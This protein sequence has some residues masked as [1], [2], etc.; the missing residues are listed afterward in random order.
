MLDNEPTT[1]AADPAATAQPAARRTAK[2][3]ATKTTTTRK[4]TVKKT[5][6]AEEVPTQSDGETADP[7][8]VKTVSYTH[9]TLPTN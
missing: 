9:L 6:A 7:A 1:E 5:A 8:P 3:A 2:K 4:R